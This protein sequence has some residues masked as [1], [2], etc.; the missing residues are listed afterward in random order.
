M[1]GFKKLVAEYIDISTQISDATKHASVLKKQRVQYQQTIIEFMKEHGLDELNTQEGT[2]VR[3]TSKT[4][5]AVKKDSVR[6][7]IQAFV[8]DNKLTEEIVDSIYQNRE[9]KEKDVLKLQKPK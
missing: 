7:Q 6:N 2:L 9:V 8:K 5:T 4:V 3:K 1:D